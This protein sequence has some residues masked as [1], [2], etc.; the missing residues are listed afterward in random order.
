MITDPT[1]LFALALFVGILGLVVL[2]LPLLILFWSQMEPQ[3]VGMMAARAGEANDEYAS[4]SVLPKLMKSFGDLADQRPA[5]GKSS[6]TRAKGK[7]RRKPAA[8]PRSKAST[9]DKT[10]KAAPSKRKPASASSSKKAT[11]AKAKSKPKSKSV[12]TKARSA[13][14]TRA[15]KASTTAKVAPKRRTPAGAKRDPILGVVYSKKPKASD[16]LKEIKGVGKVIEGK[17]H[18]AGIYTFCQIVDWDEAAI[19]AFSEKLSFKGRVRNENW[20]K[21]CAKFL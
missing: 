8:I 7:T 11:S 19:D 12:A 13:T 16:D 2:I 6:P 17:L 20:Q 10:V 14:A 5:G 9:T 4:L 18:Q 15:K 21:Q 1:A 3:L